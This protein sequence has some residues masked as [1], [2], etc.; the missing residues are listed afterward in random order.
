M[1]FGIDLVSM[2]YMIPIILLAIAVHE[3]SHAYVAYKL[4]DRS[5][6]LQGRISLDPFVHMDIIGFICIVVFRFGWGKPVYVDDSNFKNKSKDNMLVSLAGP[7]SNLILAIVFTIILKILIMTNL[8]VLLSTNN[9]GKILITMLQY[10]IQYNVIFA[11]FNMLPFPPL[12]GSK[13]LLHFLPYKAKKIVYSLEQYSF[14]IIIILLV[15]GMFGLIINPFVNGITYLLN[16]I[17]YL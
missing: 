6:K 2:L 4:G 16:L 5:Q 14:Y 11:V 3:C 10:F 15:T 1:L 13:I 9:I 7:V 17:L 12:D 8:F